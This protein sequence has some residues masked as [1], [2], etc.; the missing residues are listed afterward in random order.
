MNLHKH[1]VRTDSPSDVKKYGW[2]EESV[3]VNDS[4]ILS[5]FGN[6]LSS[7]Y[8]D[9]SESRQEQLRLRV[10][11]VSACFSPSIHGR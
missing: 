2:D 1:N 8:R 4:S 3:A 10:P 11:K 9:S 7:N 6:G 5:D